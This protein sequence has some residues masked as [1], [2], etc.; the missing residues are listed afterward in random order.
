MRPTFRFGVTLLGTAL[1]A[2]VL[3]AQ[4][5]PAK[6][7]VKSTFPLAESTLDREA[8]E[9]AIA[10]ARATDVSTTVPAALLYRGLMLSQEE[11]Y[12]EA[13]P[14]LE[15]ALRQDPSQQAGWE[16]LGWAYIRTDRKEQAWQLWE[17]FQQLM[18]NEWMPYNLL[19]QGAIMKQD[20][21][22]ADVHFKKALELKPD[23]FDLRFWYARNLLRIGE[24]DEA[25]Q[26]FRQL[27]KEEPDRLDIQIDLA[28]LLTHK[29]EY[30]EAVELFRHI[31]EELPGNTG[32]MM[33]QAV[34]E[35]RVGE[36]KRADQ[37]CLDVLELEPENP[38]AMALRADIAE[39]GNLGDRSVD[40]LKKV[41][42]NT[43]DP[44]QRGTLRV[45]MA[46]R[47]HML[48]QRSP[49][50]F[51]TRFILDQ[52]RQAIDE[53]PEDVAIRT[54]YAERLLQ[55]RRYE[56]C[57]GWAVEVLEKYNRHNL[58]A[59]TLLFELALVE[60]RFED[61][62]QILHDRF[63][64]FDPT[65]PMRYYYEARLLVAQ[66]AYREA[67]Q[68][69]DK[70]E[71]AAEQ[72]AVFT[73]LY[74]DL[75]ESDWVPATSVRRL[76][77][78]LSAL[79]REG[80]I[81]ISPT[82]IPAVIGLR[83]GE[84]RQDPESEEEAVPWTARL[85]DHVRYGVTG[86]KKFKSGKKIRPHK[87]PMK[88]VAV[89]FDDAL[90]SAFA[91]G[92]S[93]AEDFGVPFGMFAITRPH[94]E[95]VPSVAAWNEMREYAASGNWI[96]GSHLYDAHYNQPID[97][98][99]KSMR[100]VLPNRIWVPE[101]NRLESMNE[102]DRRMRREFR[103]SHKVLHDEMGEEAHPVDMVAYPFGDIGQE[104]ACNLAV[105]KNP[106][107]S[108]ISEA[109]RHYQVGFLQGISGYTVSGDNLM[110]V[111]RY[112]PD[113]AD[114]GADVVRHAYEYHPVFM[115][116]R[117]RVEIAFLM[118]KPH[119]AEEMLDLL[120]R[121][122]YP[123]ELCR[124]I[125]VETRAHF[126]N[127][128]QRDVRPLVS[129]SM[130]AVESAAGGGQTAPTHSAQTMQG[131]PERDP[132]APIDP[133]ARE[134]VEGRESEFK[135]QEGVGHYQEGNP[136][137]WVYL[138]H[139]F[140]GGEVSHS[141]AN[142]QFEILRY[143]GRAGLNLNRN[144]QLS[145]EYFESRIEQRFRARWNAISY[146]PDDMT[147]Y[148]FK[149]LK[150]EA[151]AR[152]SYRT[153]SGATLSGS[154]GVANL[155]PDYDEDD[156]FDI[157]MEDYPESDEFDPA[158]DDNEIIGDLSAHWAPRDDLTLFVYYARDLVTSAVKSLTSD[159][160]GAVAR[161]KPKD[162]WHVNLRSQYW[163]YEDD[164]A[165]FYIQGESF[166]EIMPDVGVWGGL[167]LSTVTSSK[168][169]DYYWTPYW[170]QRLLGVLRYLQAWQGY[171]F[172]LDLLGGLQREDGRPLRRSDDEDLGG[173]KSDWELVWGTS[174]TYNK[175]L[176]SYFDLF[177]D[178]SV[179]AL[180]DYIDHR[181][182]IGFNLGF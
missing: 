142:D 81:L 157:D 84:R 13:A 118:N 1:T 176:G 165:L 147:R 12:A 96:I 82:D 174:A 45:R 17:Y 145:A 87:S 119:L 134:A 73:L 46:N 24:P 102:W 175:R 27:I 8:M 132:N 66:G 6:P 9:Q 85:I 86:E 105:L 177:V 62:E 148:L 144:L 125:I 164:N 61:A 47:C 5:P 38:R 128:P 182:L 63:S 126:R 178:G 172:R 97:K 37:L 40:R 42:D 76:H 14:F 15:E 121:D 83:P 153:A 149:A 104:S 123:E 58:R 30:D 130:V 161:W 162:S 110:L 56:E 117:T 151:R 160:V 10:E 26:V 93:V 59:K 31:N 22:A 21:R 124:K 79:Q 127:R 171:T 156:L 20:W 169:S 16:A 112:E 115:A 107:Q 116:R 33:E 135:E 113:W 54:L 173:G 55:A 170:D 36:L 2:T 89:T 41:I 74:H 140:I 99:G 168:A 68:R 49:G 71:A 39:I 103:L 67:L 108:I 120:K 19:A 44:V 28:N 57:K 32:F 163:S 166:W 29:L 136:D 114:E 111:R 154:L 133:T 11:R 75:T 7:P 77:E 34:L 18:P 159:S 92:S 179:M 131:A 90:R 23:L 3:L 101:K 152:L 98:E 109:A 146:D 70:M 180:R 51:S 4:R 78:H 143:G 52:I 94:K 60:R 181:F 88:V 155:D 95:Y 139:P 64:N 167:D 129:T 25:E 141:K 80:F 106:M 91:L 150:R 72:G 69:L 43:K 138:S 122:G 50:L 137:P 53:N 100:A 35:L 65:D 48:N 158:D